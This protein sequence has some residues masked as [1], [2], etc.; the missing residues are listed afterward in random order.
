MLQLND[1]KSSLEHPEVTVRV[2]FSLA[3]FC[4]FIVSPSLGFQHLHQNP[5][6][7][8]KE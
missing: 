2:G 6:P 3:R 8:T 7:I 1:V 5:S 4:F